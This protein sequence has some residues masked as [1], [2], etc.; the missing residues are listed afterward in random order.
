MSG[1][2][3]QVTKH[4]C[5]K[6]MP[7]QYAITRFLANQRSLTDPDV[8]RVN[9]GESVRIRVINMESS[10][11]FFLSTGRLDAQVIAVDGEDIVPLSGT[12]FELGVAPRIDL[13]VQIPHGGGAYPW[14]ARRADEGLVASPPAD[15]SGRPPRVGP[16]RSG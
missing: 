13:S 16:S 8:V 5:G 3:R 15:W 1:H 6:A 14:R 9:E 7:R 11:N 4:T 12:R 2:V 10:S